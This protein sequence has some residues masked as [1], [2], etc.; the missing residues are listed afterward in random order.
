MDRWQNADDGI[1]SRNRTQQQQQQQGIAQHGMAAFVKTSGAMGMRAGAGRHHTCVPPPPPH[2]HSI[3]T[4]TTGYADSA[5]LG[6]P[7]LPSAMP[8]DLRFP[9]SIVPPPVQRLAR[10]MRKRWGKLRWWLQ[11]RCA[12]MMPV[13]A[14]CS[15][16]ILGVVGVGRPRDFRVRVSS[17][18][19]II[20]S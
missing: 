16:M 20:P 10:R 7:H 6:S 12:L 15:M 1:G 2:A 3:P 17:W 14:W 18:N 9:F 8:H 19:A 13:A 4:Q 11:S 5:G